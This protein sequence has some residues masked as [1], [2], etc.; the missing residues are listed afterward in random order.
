MRFMDWLLLPL[1]FVI[2]S[3]FAL[4]AAIAGP[5]LDEV[6]PNRTRFA[7]VRDT[8]SVVIIA[9]GA[10]AIAGW[11]AALIAGV[12]SALLIALA[13]KRAPYTIMSALGIGLAFA[14][15]N[16]TLLASAAIIAII[17]NVLAGAL[18]KERKEALL[19]TITQPIGILLVAVLVTVLS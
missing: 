12:A 17:A 18:H 16:R 8:A 5:V 14:S 3:G 4:G 6:R 10:Y 13:P 9:I 11:V 1:V 7:F 19:Q 2:W 15:G